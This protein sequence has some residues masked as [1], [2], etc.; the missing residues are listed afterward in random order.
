ML[1]KNVTLRHLVVKEKKQIGFQFS[2]DKVVDALIQSLPNVTWSEDFAM[3]FVPN[4][5]E[6]ISL[7]FEKF[8]GVA[9]VNGNYFFD[10][11]KM[12]DE[13]TPIKISHYRLRKKKEGV[14]YCPEEYYQKL[15]TKHY[16]FNTAKSYISMFELFMNNFY[17]TPLIEINEQD[18]HLYLNKLI[19][20]GKSKSYVNV[21][22]NAIKFY[23][24]VVNNMPNRFYRVDRPQKTETLPKVISL[25]EVGAILNEVTNIK[26]KCIISL[27]YSAGLRRAELLALKP[28]DVDS[29]RM[30]ILVRNA[31]GG[32]DRQ[33]L[34]SETVLIDLRKYYKEYKPQE[35]LFEG[36]YGKQYSATSVAKIVDKYAKKANISK[37]V[38]PHMLRHSFATHLLENKTDLRYIQVLMGHNST[39]TTEIYTQ[40]ATNQLKTIKSPIE[41]LYLK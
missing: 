14:C 9:W 27:L 10:T 6:N 13:P 37:K 8:K 4:K 28:S 39:K 17:P 12:G 35:Y 26:H 31:K 25:E 15:E 16:S 18:I 5:R 7:I 34:L 23:Y 33:T 38:T 1:S 21:M 19:A 24:E 3:Y 20:Q 22:I 30:I 11:K 41:L 40:V 29:K 32:K 36:M 2:H